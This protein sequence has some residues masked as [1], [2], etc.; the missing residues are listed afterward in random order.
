MTKILEMKELNKA[1]SNIRVALSNTSRGLR[2]ALLWNHQHITTRSRLS[3]VC[4]LATSKMSKVESR[5]FVLF[6]Q[7]LICELTSGVV[8]VHS[9]GCPA[10]SH[11]PLRL[12]STAPRK[13]GATLSVDQKLM[14]HRKCFSGCRGK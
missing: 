7:I 5:Q 2:M 3:A 1:A 10:P 9:I 13:A 12:A 11:P 8:E 14:S 6:S 4:M